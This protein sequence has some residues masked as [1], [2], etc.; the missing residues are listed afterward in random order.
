MERQQLLETIRQ[1]LSNTGFY[2]SELCSMRPVG[3]DLV[4]RRDN[5]LLIIKVL[6]NID[7]LTENVAKELLTLSKLLNGAPVLIGIKSGAQKLEGDVVYYRHNIPSISSETLKNNLVEGIPLEIYAA[8]GGLYVKLDHKLISEMREKQNISL[9]SLARSL[10]VSRRTVQMYEDGM[11]ASIDVA[12]RIEELL[13]KPI[14]KPIDLFERI[15]FN[16]KDFKSISK[17][18][19]QD[20][21]KKILSN[22]EKVGYR[23]IPLERSPFE[24]VSKD[25]KKILL[26]CVN[27]YDNKIIKKAYMISNISKITEK[28]AVII[29]DKKTD[30]KNIKGTPLIFD[31]ELKKIRGPEEIIELILERLL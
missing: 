16:E 9:G 7:A 2:V 17:E 19:I 11:N 27:R 13:D 30:K 10:K 8:P 22:L 25:R 24:A 26:T 20:F 1:T 31:K 15:P 23:V 3:F 29:T 5:S 6:T 28:P 12:I 18:N 14:T 4:A 21:Q